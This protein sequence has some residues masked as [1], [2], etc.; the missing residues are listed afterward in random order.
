MTRCLL[1]PT[2]DLFILVAAGSMLIVIVAGTCTSKY[3]LSKIIAYA[4]LFFSHCFNHNSDIRFKK[5]KQDG[6]Y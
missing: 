1:G 2:T 4:A 5:K 6:G 3:I